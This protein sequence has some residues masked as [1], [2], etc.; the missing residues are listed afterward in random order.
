MRPEVQVSK[1]SCADQSDSPLETRMAPCQLTLLR[2]RS[3][4]DPETRKSPCASHHAEVTEPQLPGNTGT[5][6]GPSPLVPPPA[7]VN[8]ICNGFR[9]WENLEYGVSFWI[10]TKLNFKLLQFSITQNA[11]FSQTKHIKKWSNT[12]VLQCGQIQRFLYCFLLLQC[13]SPC[14]ISREISYKLN[15]PG[16]LR[17]FC[18]LRLVLKLSQE[19]RSCYH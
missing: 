10:K 4:P 19:G 15:R 18:T 8:C 16:L 6:R 7:V 12:N 14:Q 3:W 9:N 2:N 5:T 17:V 13:A 11:I 1:S